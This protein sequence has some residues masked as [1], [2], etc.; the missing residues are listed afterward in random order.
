MGSPLSEID[1]WQASEKQTLTWSVWRRYK[2]QLLT[3]LR[4]VAWSSQAVAVNEE[5]ILNKSGPHD[6]VV[7]LQTTLHLGTIHCSIKAQLQSKTF[8]QYTQH[9]RDFLI[10]PCK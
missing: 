8:R 1:E 9:E 2:L 5:T 4:S 6:T 3:L 10:A 7:L